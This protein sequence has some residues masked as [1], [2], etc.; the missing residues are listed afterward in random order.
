MKSLEKKK[1]KKEGDVQDNF[2]II[3]M[4]KK[5][6]R[7]LVSGEWLLLDAQVCAGV[8]QTPTRLWLKRCNTHAFV[9]IY[10]CV[11]FCINTAQKVGG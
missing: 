2:V 4:I 7:R 9:Y 6:R 1:T 3:M 8:V 10:V 5:K 11:W